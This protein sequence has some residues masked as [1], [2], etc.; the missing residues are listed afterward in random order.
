MVPEAH[1]CHRVDRRMRIRIPEKKGD[2]GYFSM[3]RGHLSRLSGVDACETN[4][5]T[6]SILLILTANEGEVADFALTNGLFRLESSPPGSPR[7]AHQVQRSVNELNSRINSFTGG[8]LDLA[9]IAFLSL[10]GV[11]IYQIALG[12]FLAPAWYTALWY[13]MNIH[14]KSLAS[15]SVIEEDAP[16]RRLPPE[17]RGGKAAE[18]SLKKGKKATRSAPQKAGGPGRPPAA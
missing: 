12:E 8:G 14:N 4:A 9:E 13:A 17:D 6:G 1:V 5:I 3:A 2:A 16:S 10:M 7:L 11:G 15:K 18:Q